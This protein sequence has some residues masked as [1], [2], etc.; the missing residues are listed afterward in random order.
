MNRRGACIALAGRAT[1]GCVPAA[2]PPRR[3]LLMGGA[4]AMLP[5]AEAWAR[6][7]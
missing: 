1:L 4:G 7:S 2:P 6:A 5:L 3:T